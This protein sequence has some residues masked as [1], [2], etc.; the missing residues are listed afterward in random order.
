MKTR[1]GLTVMLVATLLA[2]VMVPLV[3]A[4]E[5]DIATS[6]QGEPAAV[7]TAPNPEDVLW[8]QYANWSGTDFAAQD[9]ESA[10]DAYDVWAADDFEN[11]E[12]W[13]I[14]TI[15]S[16]GGWG[17]FQDLN[18]ATAIHWYICADNGG[19]PDCVPGDGTEFWDEHLAPTDP[20]V[21]LGV[22]EAEDFIVTLD[23]PISLPAGTWWIIFQISLEFG[24]YGQYGISGTA[25]GAW[26][27]TVAQINPNGGFGQGSDWWINENYQDLM[28]RLEGTAGGGED[29]IHVEAIDGYFSMDYMGRPILRSYVYVADDEGSMMPFVMVDAA[30]WVPDGG[31]HY[32]SRFTKYSGAARF[33]WGSW[34]YGDWELCVDD[35]TLAGYTY[36]PG[37]NVLTCQDWYY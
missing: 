33:H 27:T 24:F 34:T 3:A 9:F 7:P 17:S 12:A 22:Y 6:A 31:P 5:P 15:V 16:R 29:T 4:G 8:D 28:F 14:D 26:G 1:I 36:E 18:N 2:S 32:R 21:A 30:I 37:D 35:L 19:L 23:T 25:D 10:Y 13:S 11:L 20:Q